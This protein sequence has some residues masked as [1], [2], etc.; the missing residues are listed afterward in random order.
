MRLWHPVPV[1]LR[2]LQQGFRTELRCMGPQ[3]R[4]SCRVEKQHRVCLRR[5]RPTQQCVIAADLGH[6]KPGFGQQ[7]IDQIQ[8]P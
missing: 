5:P 8:K 3:D 2:G 7:L 1:E 6:R 4:I